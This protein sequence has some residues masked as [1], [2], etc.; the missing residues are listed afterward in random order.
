MKKKY[1]TIAL[2]PTLIIITITLILLSKIIENKSSNEVL[3]NLETTGI[4]D[5]KLP[6][7]KVNLSIKKDT[8]SNNKVTLILSNNSSY[9]IFYGEGFHLEVEKDNKWYILKPLNSL[10][11]T[12]Q[13]FGLNS[14]KSTELEIDWEYYYGTLTPG[15]YR[16]VKEVSYNYIDA[17]REDFKIA[18]EFKIA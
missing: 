16:I 11:F 6:N 1:I 15:K 18:I 17:N 7:N 3:N 10:F 14:K 4:S 12:Y 9:H 8:L 5:I 13:L 2:I